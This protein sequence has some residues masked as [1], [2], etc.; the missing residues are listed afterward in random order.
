MKKILVSCLALLFATTLVYADSGNPKKGGK[1]G[2]KTISIAF[3]NLE[4]LFDTEDDPNTND[5]EFLPE[6]SYHWTEEDLKTKITNLGKVISELGDEDGPEILGVCEVENKAVLERLVKSKLLK[7][8]GYAV[9]HHDSPDQRGIDCALLYKKKRFLPL[10]TKAY[11][12]DFP[13][14]PDLKTRDIFLVKGILDKEIEVTFI[15]N[16]W[17]SRRGGPA[18]SSFKRERAAKILRAVVDSIQNMDPFANIV[19][20]GDF[21][22]GPKDKSV[23]EVLRTGKDS[24][25]ARYR[26]L[27]NCMYKLKEEG[28]G[29]LKFRGKFNLFDQIIVST[30]M[31]NQSK[32]R[33]RYVSCSAAIY[34]PKWM[35][36]QKEGDW[37]D[38]PKRS[39]IRREFHKDGYSDHF[40]VYIHLAY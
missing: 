16:H 26:N 38:A 19:I 14:N 30:P 33:L 24:L 20:M 28:N 37:K 3:Y 10:Y 4:N 13:E 7:K 40:P 29:T 39:H 31:A 6:G 35:R 21:N 11:T 17:S 5:N 34:N 2:K 1:K 12:V 23:Y 15:V 18:K 9:A 8:R 32:S 36:V 25:E 22:D 27:F